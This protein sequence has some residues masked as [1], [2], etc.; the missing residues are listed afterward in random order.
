[1]KEQ[2]YKIDN[3]QS[4]ELADIFDCGSVLDGINKK[5]EVIQEYLKEM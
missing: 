3:I 4:F 1:M 5:M 2:I